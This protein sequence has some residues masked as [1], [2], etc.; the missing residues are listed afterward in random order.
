MFSE[1][2]ENILSPEESLRVLEEQLEA[3]TRFS[4]WLSV[5]NTGQVDEVDNGDSGNYPSLI[6]IPLG[7]LELR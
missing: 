1:S 4:Q 2:D 6:E 5:I 7:C 3:R